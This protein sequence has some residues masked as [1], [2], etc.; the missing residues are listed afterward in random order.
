MG[1]ELGMKMVL[2]VNQG[3]LKNAV[4]FVKNVGTCAQLSTNRRLLL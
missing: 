2:E 3:L 1:F 4:E